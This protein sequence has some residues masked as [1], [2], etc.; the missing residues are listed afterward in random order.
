MQDY[1]DEQLID[2]YRDGDESALGILTSRYFD[3]IYRYSYRFARD[4]AATEDIV[5]DTFIKVWKSIAHFNEGMT[6]KPWL[7]RIAHNTAIDYLRKKKMIAFSQMTVGDD[8][9]G[10]MSIEEHFSDES[11]DIMQETIAKEEREALTQKIE[12]LPEHYKQVVLLRAEDTLTFEEIAATL[13]KPVNTVKSLYRRA[14]QLLR[15]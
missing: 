10:S 4:A 2:A 11:I 3:A 7:Y 9:E 14:L 12:N 15:D 1:S 6:F 8:V 5:Q 13:E